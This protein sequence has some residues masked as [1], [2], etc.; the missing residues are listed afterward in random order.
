MAENSERD[1]DLLRENKKLK[2]EMEAMRT[3][4]N[5][6]MERLEQENSTLKERLKGEESQKGILEKEIRERENEVIGVRNE[7]T[8][9]K[10]QGSS[11]RSLDIVQAGCEMLQV[12]VEPQEVCS[13]KNNR[14]RTSQAKDLETCPI[15]KKRAGGVDWQQCTQVDCGQWVH[16]RCEAEQNK[17][18]K[19][20]GCRNC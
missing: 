17:T 18:Y 3:E 10:E 6:E 1:D 9:L 4:F 7:L 13:R 20:P 15:C 12:T 8:K 5:N 14:S 19:C 16:C 11:K 2:E